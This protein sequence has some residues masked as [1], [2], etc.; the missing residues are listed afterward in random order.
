MEI[1]G[2]YE[3]KELFK[4]KHNTN[5]FYAAVNS[6]CFIALSQGYNTFW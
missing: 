4:K 5:I 1:L 6:L 3:D 2:K